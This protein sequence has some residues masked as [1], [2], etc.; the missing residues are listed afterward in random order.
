MPAPLFP[1]IGEERAEYAFEYAWCKAT[2]SKHEQPRLAG[3]LDCS[4]V[5]SSGHES[6]SREGESLQIYGSTLNAVKSIVEGGRMHHCSSYAGYVESRTG[7]QV[8]IC[9]A[10]RPDGHYGSYFGPWG[11][12]DDEL[13]ASLYVDGSSTPAE[14][15]CRS[16]LLPVPPNACFVTFCRS[17]PD[18]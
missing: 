8:E 14:E 10:F 7:Q 5:A 12:S 6:G 17:C 4:A 3:Y 13:L 16:P 11:N 18:A 15:V 1:S 9:L 2:N